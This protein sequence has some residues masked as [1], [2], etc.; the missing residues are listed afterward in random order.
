[1]ELKGSKQSREE[2]E[3]EAPTEGDRNGVRQIANGGKT[4]R[5]EVEAKKI[6]NKK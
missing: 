1:M 2:G 6:K 5:K 4:K 3:G